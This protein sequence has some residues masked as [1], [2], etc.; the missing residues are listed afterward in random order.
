MIRREFLKA[1]GAAAA[2]AVV[3][4]TVARAQAKKIDVKI[5]SRY[6]PPI[7]HMISPPIF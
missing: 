1:A 5:S 6:T 2:G 7:T 4:P 3:S